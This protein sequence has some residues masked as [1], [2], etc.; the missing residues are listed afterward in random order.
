M[1]GKNG[2]VI[3]SGGFER[4]TNHE[5]VIKKIDSIRKKTKF[6]NYVGDTV[7]FH[8]NG[9]LTFPLLGTKANK[10]SK[11]EF[12]PDRVKRREILGLVKETFSDQTVFIGGSSSF[13]IVPRGV[14]KLSALL[15]YASSI[16]VDIDE[17]VYFGDDYGPGGNDEDIFLSNIEFICVDDYKLFPQKVDFILDEKK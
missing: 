1:D 3:A 7:E 16:K 8:P 4:V 6:D 13:D 12:D 17:I 2:D 11:L 15:K 14:N 10:E 9:M 5:E